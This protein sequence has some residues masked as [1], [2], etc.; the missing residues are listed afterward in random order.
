MLGFDSKNTDALKK[1]LLKIMSTP[2]SFDLLH[3]GGKSEWAASPLLSHAGI[4][5]GVCSYEYSD[6]LARKLANPD[7][8]TLININVQRQFSGAMRSRSMK[9]AS[10]QTHGLDRLD[11]RRNVETSARRR[12]QH[13]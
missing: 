6:W 10:I 2:I 13:V 1:A 5:N 8:Y 7:I 12:R 11:S 9:T 3:E 4:R